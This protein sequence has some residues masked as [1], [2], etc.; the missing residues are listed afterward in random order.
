MFLTI[1]YFMEFGHSGAAKMGPASDPQ[2]V[3]NHELKVRVFTLSWLFIYY[4][5]YIMAVKI[6]RDAGLRNPKAP[7][8]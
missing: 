6:G 1:V 4:F 2:S 5:L 8:D 7:R 3:V